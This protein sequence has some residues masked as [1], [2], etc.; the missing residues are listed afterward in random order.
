MYTRSASI[1]QRS[2]CSCI[3]C[4]GSKVWHHAWLGNTCFYRFLFFKFVWRFTLQIP[5]CLS[6]R[7]GWDESAWGKE[8][9]SSRS[10]WLASRYRTLL[11][12]GCEW[13]MG[14]S[15]A[16]FNLYCQSSPL[17]LAVA[18]VLSLSCSIGTGSSFMWINLVRKHFPTTVQICTC[19]TH[20][21]LAFILDMFCLYFF[22]FI[23]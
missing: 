11:L 10:S 1:L 2:I 8:A 15:F 7:T 16:Q 23:F 13:T 18:V 14:N 20:P 17:V 19:S 6:I 9:C 4:A 12:G 21:R 5:N 3:L 22:F